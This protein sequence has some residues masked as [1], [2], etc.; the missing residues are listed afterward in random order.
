MSR[1]IIDTH[2]HQWD[3]SRFNLPWLEGAGPPLGADHLMSD[4]LTVTES[5]NIVKTVYMEVDMSLN[6]R[7]AEAEYV[8]SFCERDDN[9]MAAAVI[10]GD[11]SSAGFEEFVRQF[12]SSPYIKGIRLVLHVPEA[13]RGKCLGDAFVN[14][15]QLLGRFGLSYDICMRPGENDDGVH[16]VD[17]CP[18]T[19]FI[20]DH[21]GNADPNV[22]AGDVTPTADELRDTSQHSADQWKRDMEEFARRDNVICKIS[23]IIARAPEGWSAATLA[24]TINHCLDSFGPDR[25]IFASDWPVCTLGA[26]LT[27]WVGALEEIVS[28]RSEEDQ[29]KL[30]HDNAARVYCLDGGN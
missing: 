25:V 13:E 29:Q 14:G 8:I 9:P 23:G 12:D 27:E 10:A 1:P 17:R 21:C 15:V 11:P 3:S 20:V 26:R 6:Q 19:R 22:V 18:D 2:Q 28:A 4:Y 5:L 16:L 24:P 7:Q 30:F